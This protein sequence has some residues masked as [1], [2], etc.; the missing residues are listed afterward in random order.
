MP[1]DT[2]GQYE[3]AERW[4]SYYTQV[5]EILGFSGATCL[6]VG[7]GNGIVTDALKRQQ[8]QVTTLD[9]D[10]TLEP[11]IVGS[12]SNIPLPDQSIDVVLCAE[13]LEH[14]PFDQFENCIKELARVSRLGLVLSLP[15]WGYTVRAIIDLPG[16][17]GVRTSWKLP[18]TTS[19]PQGI[20]EWEIGRKG[21]PLVRIAS[22]IKKY[23]IL[24]K[25][26]VSPWMPYHHFF[27]L[28]KHCS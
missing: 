12:V 13:V 14:L 4:T 20:H 3:S 23:F 21:Y 18:V 17:P 22:L 7:V 8:I 11:D 25:D 2:W 9:I 16:L 6:E 5:N 19:T 15:H 28:V 1:Y 10:P 27:R 26:W 24:Q